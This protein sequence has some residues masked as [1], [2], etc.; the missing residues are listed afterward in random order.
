MDDDAFIAAAIRRGES[1]GLTA[2]AGPERVIWLISEAEACSAM[3]EFDSFVEDHE[4]VQ[5]AECAAAFAAV[6]ATAI[7][8][9]I[10]Q[11]SRDLPARDDTAFRRVAS[12][13]TECHEY[14]YDQIRQYVN[15]SREA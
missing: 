5:V 12:W 1:H 10:E 2:L 13:I 11:I 15:V 8:A 9:E 4:P 6:G 3:D 14:D 7:A